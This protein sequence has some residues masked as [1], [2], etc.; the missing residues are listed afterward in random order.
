M[1]GREHEQ[2]LKDIVPPRTFS[3]KSS[4]RFLIVTFHR[5]KGKRIFYSAEGKRHLE[6]MLDDFF[7]ERAS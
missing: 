2:E 7:K 3:K 4:T 6:D 5:E 1:V